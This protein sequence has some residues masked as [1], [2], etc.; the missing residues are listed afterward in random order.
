MGG[1]SQKVLLHPGVHCGKELSC[2]GLRLQKPR[3]LGA[4]HFH[5]AG[6]NRLL[7]IRF[8]GFPAKR[9]QVLP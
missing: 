7:K 2:A 9:I 4:L 8:K 3:L 6:P 1:V 5:S